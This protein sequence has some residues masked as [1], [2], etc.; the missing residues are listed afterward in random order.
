MT[1]RVGNAEDSSGPEYF[2]SLVKDADPVEVHL[3]QVGGKHQG[4]FVVAA[5]D[6][7]DDLPAAV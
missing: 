7:A 4:V 6:D 1:S 5:A 2:D 3:K